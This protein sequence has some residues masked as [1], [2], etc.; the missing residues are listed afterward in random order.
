MPPMTIIEIA[1]DSVTL[2]RTNLS[3]RNFF[4]RCFGISLKSNPVPIHIIQKSLGAEFLNTVQQVVKERKRAFIAE[5]LPDGSVAN[6]F[7]RSL[8]ENP[9][10]KTVAVAVCG[11]SIT[12]K[13]Q[14][15]TFENIAKA[16]SADYY[17]LFYVNI[18]TEEYTEYLSGFGEGIMSSERKGTSFFGQLQKDARIHL[19]RKQYKRADDAAQAP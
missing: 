18:E 19:R 1:E 9:V 14:E 11:L 13:N 10:K 12:D 16:L 4:T 17:N 5:V 8:T 2:I 15:T 6:F 3:Y 7:V